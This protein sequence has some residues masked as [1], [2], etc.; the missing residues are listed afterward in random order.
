MESSDGGWTHDQWFNAPR[1]ALVVETAEGRVFVEG[2]FT[3]DEAMSRR[4]RLWDKDRY[5]ISLAEYRD[6]DAA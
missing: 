5:S 1:Y 4:N 6:D 2:P 3:E